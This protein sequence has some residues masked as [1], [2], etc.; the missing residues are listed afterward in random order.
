MNTLTKIFKDRP[1]PPLEN[2]VWWIE[3]LLRHEDVNQFI[4]SPSIQQPWWKRRQIDVWLT[5]SLLI[6]LV[7]SPPLFVI[8][9]LI[10]KICFGASGKSTTKSKVKTN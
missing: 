5:A 2:A 7:V 1:M 10:S 4:V 3:Y 6:F 8:W 9:T